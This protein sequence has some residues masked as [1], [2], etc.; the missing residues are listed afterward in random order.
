[1]NDFSKFVTNIGSDRVDKEVFSQ[2]TPVP[3][4]KKAIVNMFDK[5]IY[6]SLFMLFAGVPLFFTGLSFQGAV[7]EKQIYF[8][9][10]VLVALVSWAGKGASTGEMKIKRTPLDIPIFLFLIVYIVSTFLSVDK[11]HSFWGFFGDPSRGLMTIISGIIVYYLILSNFNKN[12]FNWIMG[13]LI[14]SSTLI[15]IFSILT[16]FDIKIFPDSLN[17]LIPLSLIGTVSGLKIFSGMMIPLIMVVSFKMNESKNKTLNILSYAILAVIPI[18]LLLISMV[19]DRTIAMIILFGVG[20]F[21]LYVLSHVVRPKESLTW[22]PMVVFVL[23]MVVLMVGKNE[24][25]K[26]NAP[27]EVAPDLKVSWEIVKGGL[28]ENPILGSG[29]ATYGYDFSKFKPQEFNSNIFYGIR[30]YQGTG[31]FFES[32]STTGVLGLVALLA[33]TIVFINIAIYLISR[34]K[35][36]NKIYSLG[37]LSAT[38]ILIISSFIFRVEGTILLMGILMGSLTMAIIFRESGIDDKYLKLSLK[39]SPKFALTLAFIFIIVSAGVATLFVY[40]GKA[41]VADIHAGNAIRQ[42]T[43]TEEGS[44]KSL[45]RA[46]TL[47]GK[48]GRYFSRLGQ[49][50]MVLANQE[51]SKGEGKIDA[52]KLKGYVDRAVAYSKEGV[53]I[54]PNDALAIS[55]LAQ[56]YESLALYANDALTFATDSY[57]KLLILEPHNPVAYLKLG[58]IKVVPAISEK[59]ETKKKAA[60]N[61]AKGYFE[62]SVKEKSNFAEGYYYLAVTQNALEQKSEVIDTLIKAVNYDRN[63]VTYQFNLGRAYQERGSNE[64][65]ENAQKIFEYILKLNP[66]E[67][68]TVFALGTI[69]DK[70]GEKEKAIEKYEKVIEIIEKIN[71]DSGDTVSKLNKMIENVRNGISNSNTTLNGQTVTPSGGDQQQA[72][73]VPQNNV[74]LV[75]P[76]AAQNPVNITT[77]PP[78]DAVDRINQ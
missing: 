47:N 54:M 66:E 51:A 41:F 25:A 18:N 76:D 62:K 49:E 56:I 14:G 16:F 24:L 50:Y 32:F 2:R 63:N 78:V 1:M 8:Y 72:P 13:G 7:F 22:I 53:A 69:Y 59:D 33:V 67:I 37:L 12:N 21:L 57:E 30:F 3:E 26:V 61:E 64:D 60:I 75:G 44:I 40:I 31:L 73:P 34:D 4:Q 23:S 52:D 48:E 65:V 45:I 11:W 5:I 71:Q 74:E 43:I 58:Q 46:V 15:S 17:T 9:F 39:A 55:V 29:P 35:E 70:K 68:N 10:W 38:L 20:F 77:P 42:K 6:V 36:K 19:F 28:K 27:I